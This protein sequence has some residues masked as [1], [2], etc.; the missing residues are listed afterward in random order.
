MNT[1][2]IRLLKIV[3]T[4]LCGGT[5]NQAITLARSL[6]EQGFS[7]EVACLRRHRA[8][9]QRA[10]RPRHPAVRV[11]AFPGFYSFAA[12]AQKAKFARHMAKH[13]IDVMHAYSFYGNVFGILPARLAATPVV[14]ASI[15][16]RGGVSHADAEARAAIRLPLCRLRARECRGRE[17]LADERRVRPVEDRRHSERRRARPLQ[18]ASGS[19]A[20]SVA[21][22][23]S[24]RA[25]RW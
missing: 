11:P 10:Q 6:H 13:R 15:R 4:L 7:L 21:S 19:R 24:P 5:E 22:S 3:P 1:A 16:D 14:I 12:L 20:R 23:A 9:R 18:R 8:V 2:P 17:G 25:R